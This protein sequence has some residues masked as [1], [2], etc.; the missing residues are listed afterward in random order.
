MVRPILSVLPC[1]AI[2]AVS[3]NCLCNQTNFLTNLYNQSHTGSLT[4]VEILAV[5][6]DRGDVLGRGFGLHRELSHL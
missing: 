4:V 1:P 3:R 6:R 5:T 2:F